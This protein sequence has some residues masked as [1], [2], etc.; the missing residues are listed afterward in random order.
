MKRNADQ[1]TPLGGAIFDGGGESFIH[2][3][4]NGRWRDVLNAADIAEYQT[5]AQAE[6]GADC[7]RWFETGQS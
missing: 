2:K 6:L 3:G 5:R 7:A 4:V 1:V